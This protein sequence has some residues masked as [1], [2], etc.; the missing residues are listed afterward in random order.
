MRRFFAE[1]PQPG[2]IFFW[3]FIALFLVAF[4]LGVVTQMRWA[5]LGA[6]GAGVLV[7]VWHV[8]RDINLHRKH[9]VQDLQGEPW[10][11]T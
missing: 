6:S 5:G 4:L 10:N 2:R 9:V 1:L 8:F 7:S 11:Q 3:C